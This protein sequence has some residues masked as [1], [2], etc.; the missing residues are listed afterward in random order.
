MDL[1]AIRNKF[2]DVS[3]EG[4]FYI[5]NEYLCHTIERPYQ[6]GANTVGQS[7][8]LPGVYPVIIDFSPHF[9]RPMPHVLNVPGRSEIR[10]HP[11]KMASQLEGCIA[12]GVTESKDFIGESQ[13]AFNK[14]FPLLEAALKS[15][16]VNIEIVNQLDKT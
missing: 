9:N 1:K 2:D 7:S 5:D 13:I 4:D 16:S 6:N 15:G 10:I 8:I 11:A 12:L 14:F 3:T